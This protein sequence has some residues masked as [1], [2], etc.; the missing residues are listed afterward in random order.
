MIRYIQLR[1]ASSD[2]PRTSLGLVGLILSLSA[3]GQ[4]PPAPVRAAE[5]RLPD[6]T[7]TLP[8]TMVRE[9]PFVEGEIQ[10]VR[11]K[12]LLDTGMRDA[13]V[14]N[15]HRVPLTG[16]EQIGSGFFGSGQ[17]FV[18]RL[19][20]SVRDLRIGKIAI[21]RVTSVRSQDA[22]Q[23]E[24]I[25]SDFVGWLGYNFFKDHALK[26]DYRRS[27]A[28]FYSGGAE[29]FLRG[30]K[31]MAVLPFQTR[32]LPNHPVLPT[33][34]GDVTGVVT[35]DTGMNGALYL[36]ASKKAALI[37]SGH[38]KATREENMY[39]LARVNLAGEIVVDIQ[40]IEVLEGPSPASKPIGITEDVELE[41]GYALLRQFKT[42]WDYK[43]KR[44]YLLAR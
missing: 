30:E 40:G 20:Q 23:L 36:P 29:K 32:T 41:L 27:Q 28:T 15:D 8:F 34:I 25:T 12:F 4:M 39:D 21:P 1:T 14:I 3:A 42:V 43:A 2:K 13:L 31:L 44:L 16:G 38:L 22:S 35:L 24:A 33:T 37:A 17:T 10:G 11:G 9:F 19:N 26:M 18:V 6:D 7:V 5:A